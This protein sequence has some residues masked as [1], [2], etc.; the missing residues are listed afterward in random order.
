M[1][2][3]FI[4]VYGQITEAVGEKYDAFIVLAPY[5]LGAI[6]VFIVGYV[7]AEIAERLIMRMSARLKLEKIAQK[8]GLTNFLK[9][10]GVKQS[11]SKVI[12][13]SVKAYL[14]FVFFIEATKVAKMTEVAQFLATIRAYIPDMIIA[15]F[16]ILVGI[17]IGN[18]LQIVVETSLSITRS[19]TS[20][21]LGMAAKYTVVAFAVLAALSQLKI[22]QILVQILFIGLVSMLALA[23]GLAF[24]LGGKDVVKELLEALKNMELID[25]VES[26]YEEKGKKREQ[27]PTL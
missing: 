1:E 17:S 10:T 3:F 23:G 20:K 11:P 6:G 24:G 2:N 25:Y 19:N 16:I 26:K 18:T 27:S 7:L 22:A 21:A 4:S 14:I 8:A 12:A 15:L 5:I 9:K 13:E